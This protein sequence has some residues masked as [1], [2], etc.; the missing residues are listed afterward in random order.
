MSVSF[1]ST[2]SA[3]KTLL[4]RQPL[5]EFKRLRRWGPHAYVRTSVWAQQ[6]EAA[7][8]RL[9]VPT[10]TSIEPALEV[11]FLTGKRFWYQTA[12]CAWTLAHSSGR[13]LAVHLADDGTLTP[14]LEQQLRR[15]FPDGRTHWREAC[16]KRFEALLPASQYPTLHQRW[17]D[18]I[19]L[20]KLTAPHLGSSGVQLVLDSDML[21]FRRPEALLHW[22]DHRDQ[23][24]LM[25]DCEESY[26]YSRPLLERLAGVP[27]LSSLN[28]GICGLNSDSID[29]D[30]LEYWCRSLV[31]AEGTCY[32]LEQALVAMLAS[33]V[34]PTVMPRAEYI[35]LPSRNQVDHGLGI[36]HHYVADSKPWYFRKAW[37]CAAGEHLQ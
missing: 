13:R 23:P 25:V 28:V 33:R 3:A 32:Y 34:Q 30:E 35:T 29:W 15:L 8:H 1:R 31:E 36:L 20:H 4:V 27:I 9:P 11:W 26:G 6:M 16:L 37:R 12:F 10:S 14:E 5:A 19:N 24:C 22:W 21:F 2:L 7:A 18:Y 17:H